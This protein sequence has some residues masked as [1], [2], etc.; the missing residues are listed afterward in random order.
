MPDPS[1][2]GTCADVVRDFATCEDVAARY[3]TL[4]DFLAAYG[5]QTTP[6]EQ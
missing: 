1:P 5:A 3:A 4:A 6:S 2:G